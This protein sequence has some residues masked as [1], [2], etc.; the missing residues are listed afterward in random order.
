MSPTE[1]AVNDGEAFREIHSLGLGY[2]KS[3]WYQSFA[4]A[5]RPNMLTMI[6]PKQPTARR[7]LFDVHL[8]RRF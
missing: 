6:D 8:A 3:A 5:E 1:I 7:K 2:N 4:D